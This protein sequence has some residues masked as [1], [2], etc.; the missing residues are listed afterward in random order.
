MELFTLIIGLVV[1]LT[2]A[3]LFLKK[4]ISDAESIAQS[5]AQVELALLNER[6]SASVEETKRLKN[7]LA[8][9]EQQG[10]TQRQQ[11]EASRSE[12][13]QLTERASRLPELEQDLK[14]ALS[15]QS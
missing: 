8:T 14:T 3:G 9:S 7:E 6:L 1:G 5:K 10:E 2:V 13:A 12:C 15:V 4:R 11:L